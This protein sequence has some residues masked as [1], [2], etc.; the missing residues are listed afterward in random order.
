MIIISARL[1]A[2][3]GV[4][5]FSPVFGETEFDVT[6]SDSVLL[7]G[8]GAPD[9][10]PGISCC[11]QGNYVALLHSIISFLPCSIPPVC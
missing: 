7:L 4:H 10:T 6:A 1:K 8:R 5:I 2:G 11:E 9:G 3:A